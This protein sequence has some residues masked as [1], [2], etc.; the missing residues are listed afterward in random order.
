[1][2]NF[3][4]IHGARVTYWDDLRIP[5]T[6]TK[7]G[8]SRDPGFAV[9][10][11]NAGG[12][13]QGVFLYWFDAGTEEELYFVAQMPHGWDRTALRPHVHWTPAVTADGDPASQK[14]LWGLEYA[15]AEIGADFPTTTTISTSTHFPAD[16]DVV[17]GRH[18][19][20]VF[21][22]IASSTSVDGLSSML[23]CRLFRDA[24]NLLDTYEHD[25]GLIE[26]DFHYAMGQAGSKQELVY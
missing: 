8:G 11:K 26:I 4:P 9:F 15:W 25:A 19:L 13:S 3:S 2:F 1:M 21:P 18:Y 5:I 24:G 12:T 14:V 10:K 23:V 16:A 17:A 22:E 20:S 6:S 7:L